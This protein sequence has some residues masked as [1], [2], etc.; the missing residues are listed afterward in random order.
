[1]SRMDDANNPYAAPVSTLAGPRGQSAYTGYAG[2]WIR[3][4]ASF[5]DGL[6]LNVVILPLSF[7]VG[8]MIGIV[9]VA[10]QIDP[11]GPGP[12]IFLNLLG[13]ILGLGGGLLYNALMISSKHQATLGKMALGL[14]VT[15]LQGQRLSLPNALGRE[16]GKW[17]SSIILLIG[18]IMAAFTEKKQ[19]LHDMMAGTYVLKTR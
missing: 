14:K 19:A 3:W 8:L 1:M 15:D 13:M 17:V 2:F 10:M 5:L 12:Q 6:I 9:M 16:A 11:S 7:M 18:F 4:V